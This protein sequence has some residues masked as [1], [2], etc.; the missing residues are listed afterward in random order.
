MIINTFLRMVQVIL[1][2]SFMKD[3]ENENYD[4]FHHFDP[5]LVFETSFL[6]FQYDLSIFNL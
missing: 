3:I 4:H 6:P 1:N 5:L 2:H